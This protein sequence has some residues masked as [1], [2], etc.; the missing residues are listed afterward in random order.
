[1]P[2]FREDICVFMATQKGTVKRVALDQF[3]RPRSN[4]VIAITSDE[5]DQLI[6]AATTN[7]DQDVM[8]FSDAG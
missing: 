7:G 3:S 8:I 2:E 1:M 4:G 5:G 6:S